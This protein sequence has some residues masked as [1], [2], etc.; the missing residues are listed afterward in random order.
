MAVGALEPQFY[1]L[2]VSGLG[3]DESTLGNRLDPGEWHRIAEVFAE[4]FAARTRQ[5][6]TAT[7][8]G[9][10]AC[11]TPVLSMDEVGE[12]PH[13][14]EREALVPTVSGPRPHPAPRFSGSASSDHTAEM[15]AEAVEAILVSLGLET[16]VVGEMRERGTVSWD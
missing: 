2:L 1:S 13:N 5:E 8:D 6:W 16:A 4:R 12:H 14:A 7:F 11:V 10:D 9:T 3:L 15:D